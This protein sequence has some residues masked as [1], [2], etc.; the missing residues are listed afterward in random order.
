MYLASLF[1]TEQRPQIEN[2]KILKT[3][4]L[5]TMNDNYQLLGARLGTWLKK[6]KLH[7]WRDSP[8]ATTFKPRGSWIT[9][10][11]LL[12]VFLFSHSISSQVTTY[13]F[14][15]SS[16]TYSEISGGTALV[17]CTDCGTAYDS[18]SY[19]VTLPTP[20]TF[21]FVSV[22][23]VVMRVDGS[24]VVGS[25]ST[26]SATGPI[27]ASTTATGVIAAL[28]MDLRNCTIAGVQYELRWQ[29][30]GSEYVFQWKNA[31]RWAQNT[32]ER[33]NFQIRIVKSTGAISIVYGDFISV[34]NSTTYQP[35][36]GLRG[37]TN[38]DFNSRV[39]TTT[40]PDATPTWD[41]T[42]V[43]TSN[44]Q[45]LRFTS[46][47]PASFPSL[48]FTYTWTPL[49]LEACVT[50]TALASNLTFSGVSTTGLNGSFTAAAPAPSKYLVV[51]ST[52][53]TPPTPVDGTVYTVGATTLGAG[54][55]VRSI[56][57]ATTFSD[58]GLTAGTQYYYHVFSYNDL[59]TGAPFYSTGA[60]TSGQATVCAAGTSISTNTVTTTSATV[61]WTGSGTYI[62]E[63]GPSV[64]F[65]PGTGATA[66]TNGTIASSS[67]T[68]PYSLTGLSSGTNYRVYVRQ[69]CPLGGYSANT[70]FA[71]FTTLCLPELAP[72]A[73]QTFTT[74]TG[75]APNPVCWTEA[76]G[77]VEAPSVLTAANSKW[78][79]S[80][81]FGNVGTNVGAK[82]NLYNT[83]PGDWLISNQID[84]G[85]TP[86]LYR[87]KYRIAVTSW[88]GTTAQASLGTHIVRV[89]V[90]TDGGTTWSS[91]NTIKTYTGEGSYSNTG[92][93]EIVDLTGYSGVVK[94]AFVSTTSSTSP[95]IDFHLDDFEVELT[96]PCLE[97]SAPTVSSFTANTAVVGW[98][99]PSTLPSNGY[100]WAVT[101]SVTPPA[102]GT[103]TTELTVNANGL[104]PNTTHYL[105]VRSNCGANGY[106]A[107][108]TSASFTTPCEAITTLPYFMGFD[109]SAPCWTISGGT[110]VWALANGSSVDISAPYEGTGFAFKPYQS[111]T[112]YLYS[113]PFNMASAGSSQVYL[114]FW[115]YR[116]VSAHINDVITFK[117]N[118][119][120]SN[121]GATTVATY[122]LRADQ[123]PVVA[124]SG[125]YNYSIAIPTSWNSAG[126]FH[127]VIEGATSAGLSSYDIGL[128]SFSLDYAP[129]TVSSFAPTY[130]CGTAGGDTITITGSNFTGATSV[131]FNGIEATSFT[132][133][134]DTTISA[135]V[136]AGNTEGVITVYK[137]PSSNGY[138]TSATAFE[139]K[140]FPT[141]ASITYQNTVVANVAVCRPTTVDLDIATGGGSWSSL[142]EA[143]A[144]VDGNG[145]VTSHQS[146]TVTINYVVVSEF[147]CVT[148]RSATVTFNEPI[149]LL[150]YTQSQTVVT[151][152]T[153]T[154]SVTTN[155]DPSYTY[156]WYSFDGIFEEALVDGPGFAGE[157]YQG[158]TSSTLQ[159]LNTP[160]DLNGFEFFCVI[161]AAAPC[162][163]VT[164]PNAILNV[165]DTG[166]ATDPQNVS[167]C[168]TGSGAAQFSVV[169]T[170]TVNSYQ[171]QLD[172]T[173]EGFW[174]DITDGSML[175]L[176]FS[177]STTNTLNVN[178]IT[179]ATSGLRFRVIVNG[180]ANSPESNP[181]VLTVNE[182]VEITT[183][184]QSA[185]VCKIAGSTQFSV[186]ASG[187][188]T[189]V[190]WKYST[191]GTTYA[192]VTN[193]LP[194][195]ITYSGQTT[196]TLTVNRTAATAVGTYYY[197]AFVSGASPC[198]EQASNAATL[199]VTAPTVAV[200][201]S[202]TTYCNPGT[203]VTLTASGAVS[204][205]WSPMTGLTF[206]GGQTAVASASPT[207]TTTYTVTGTDSNGCSST[208][209]VTVTVNPGVI[210]SLN[211]PLS[212]VCSGAAVPFTLTNSSLIGNPK[213]SGY[214][215][216]S[217][218][219]TY[220][221]VAGTNSTAIGDD[222]NQNTISLGFTFK[223]DGVD[224]TTFSIN[225]NG[226]IRLGTTIAASPWI[227]LLSNTAAQRPLIAPFW[228][229]NHRNAGAIT[230][231]VTGSSPNRILEV[232]WDGI[233]IGG[234][235]STS[236]ANVASYKLRLYE[237]TNVIDF[238]YGP[239]M[240]T[241]GALTA[242][243]G[244]NGNDSFLSVNPT[245][246]P[247]VSSTT[248]SNSINSTVNLVG[249]RFRFTPNV[250]QYTYEWSSVP[251]GFTSSVANPTA[252]PTETT[253]YSV[254]VTGPNGCSSTVS[255]TIT[256][257]SGVAIG[258]QPSAVGPLCQ[259]ANTSF[260][261]V[262]SGPSLQ[263]QWRK[264][265]V[266]VVGN[267][268]ATTATLVLNGVL[269]SQ[270]GV[271][272]V[273]ITPACGE[274]VLSTPQSLIVYP[275]P[276][277]EPIAN[278]NYCSGELA[279]VTTLSGTPAGVT[280]D[281][282]GG[283]AVGLADQ[284]GV[285]SIPSFA[286]IVGSATVTVTPKA[287]G[288]TGIARTYTITVG[289]KPAAIDLNTYS[290]A[291]CSNDN[292]VLLSA[293]GGFD[294][295]A[296]ILKQ[297]FNSGLQGWTVTSGPS[298]PSQSN[299]A[300]VQSPFNLSG[301]IISFTN[302]STQNGGGFLFSNADAGGSGSITNT[303]I[304]SP[305]FS[306][307][308][309]TSSVLTFEH[310]YRYWSSDS[311]VRLEISTNDGSTWSPLENYIGSDKGVTTN[312]SQ[313]T[314]QVSVNLNAYLNQ[315]SLRIRFNYLTTWGYYWI[316]DNVKVTGPGQ[317]A[318]TW[319]PIEGLYTD[320]AATLPYQGEATAS[321]YARPAATQSFVATVNSN[322]G[323]ST[324]S[325]PVQIN[326]TQATQWYADLDGDG[327]G[328]INNPTNFLSCNLSEPGFVTIAG[329]CN[330]NNALIN[331]G[332]A[333]ICFDG[334]D[335]NCDG[336]L[337]ANCTP[338]VVNI[339][340]NVCGSVNNGLN[341]TIQSSQVN[342]GGGYVIGYRFEVTNTETGEVRTIDRNVH[343]FKLTM[344]GD[345]F[346]NYGTTYSIRVAAI[347]NGEV[348][349]YNGATCSI[350]TTSV[351]TTSIVASQCGSTLVTMTS[352][353]NAVA[354]NP[355][356]SKYRFRVARADAPTTFYYVER[357]VP[358]FNLTLVPG[359]PLTFATEY[360][361]A[362]QIRVKLAGFESWSQWSTASCSVFTPVAPTTSVTEADC[363]FIATSNT[364]V[365]HAIPV[366]GATMY[367][368]LLLGFDFD[369]ND[370]MIIVYE[371]FVDTPNPYFT[372][373]MFS[374][375]LPDYNY[376]VSVAVELFGSF[377]PYGKDCSVTTPSITGCVNTTLW[378]SAT[379]TPTCTG[380]AQNITTS[381][382]AGEY[383]NLNLT[384]GVT[385]TLS[386]STITDF[387][388]VT[389]SSN[390]FLV[391]GVT[392]VTFTPY[393]SGVYKM[394]V[395]TNASC[396]SQSSS[397][398]TRVS[399]SN[400]TLRQTPIE[401]DTTASQVTVDF[402][403]IGYP[404]PY[405]EYFT[406]DV[407]SSSTETV[408][409]AIY[410]MTGRLLE[411]KDLKHT[412]L[413][414]YR[415][416][417]AYPSGVYNV[418]VIQGDEM[419]T[420]RMVKK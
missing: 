43:A 200:V 405:V 333:E 238:V 372:L 125:W 322:N 151:G 9:P 325:A 225:T 135:V 373:S 185:L 306:T 128:D 387:I 252:N 41:D 377:T 80:T 207:A 161:T 89:I 175:G 155:A 50:P 119:T 159:I 92:Q 348:Q 137:Q 278:Q 32:V 244:L 403:V 379:F 79:S 64:G 350:T 311:T 320:L 31:S 396:G 236:G 312:N 323:C 401:E 266:A 337:F 177:N 179:L 149:S 364:D 273:M 412:E 117:L 270:S 45:N 75:S 293:T 15:Q 309:A 329:D 61:T 145:V 5:R 262:A 157:T 221:P 416:G 381:L 134:N 47:A 164:S 205:T 94:I 173:V 192:N 227:N 133:V 391:T 224:Y 176:T 298:S 152:N 113:P 37:A 39:L 100:E 331:P 106:S 199:Q 410:D 53:A 10:V 23:S 363:E 334:I 103:P 229:D 217:S 310:L 230:Y 65:T 114:N 287:N 108:V 118:A 257:S 81:G 318:I 2:N 268:T 209:T 76:T 48:G 232:G 102:S 251:A 308:G 338:I 239:V 51:R 346:Y 219:E 11:L 415:L 59:C 407:R 97:P 110:N 66:G 86:G 366:P 215:F 189:G 122:A 383:S 279:N 231:A 146:G 291:I 243:V 138:G 357:T 248:A 218:T 115:L 292:G 362:V 36:V 71:S 96:P 402:K 295:D 60:L 216:E 33:L 361:V 390:A 63:Y 87:L 255:K 204:Y 83:F 91:A 55:N 247:S 324:S 275:T 123:A 198:P 143:I 256:V 148:T 62:V 12:F 111:S 313:V 271:Y 289:Q 301:T 245:A 276:T 299:W 95:D 3:N 30:V 150:D 386:S 385:Y 54:T 398:T 226:F 93:T 82:I 84:L 274:S 130:V 237:T 56:T 290:E 336:S 303:V 317:G 281:V 142:N 26:S 399:C 136:P 58:S 395:N 263:Y 404:N 52:S 104:T 187:A 339:T 105:H 354:V 101:T 139:V 388:T 140:P 210:V 124:S 411:S 242:S 353:I 352:S 282:T 184:P 165:G 344:F 409:Y 42:A 234:G 69:V 191:D 367:R 419:Q 181:A 283:A 277:L 269:P 397:R 365:I 24:L 29:D 394:H 371:Q 77:A 246:T 240:N 384:A 196:T 297:D 369:A 7:V 73:V 249:K 393:V 235:G 20:F 417:S 121:T 22:S 46:G 272:D 264:D 112:Q 341:N 17:S 375:L 167:L 85:A 213:V 40:V 349:P 260:S 285:T 342:L 13:T 319:S 414:S 400:G 335:N 109:G 280:F 302:F 166:I 305:S 214:S 202:S 98:S 286:V 307:V 8:D 332:V 382:F 70:T 116:N 90:S 147:G 162:E 19:V 126:T 28:G 67:A 418:I 206:E 72:T 314:A 170:G 258:T 190:Q 330:D 228:D 188:T 68:S 153:A 154:Y 193:N 241:A 129:V 186:A 259:G 316:L 174:Q 16:G 288:C 420:I 368:F 14:S 49:V 347:V 156:Q 356:P 340:S 160:D 57:N 27:S 131:Q 141:V 413:E 233:N 389:S 201:A 168:S 169:S 321:V 406:L 250:P 180:P 88:N 345:D 267:A 343:H 380:V 74:F 18:N 158:A 171:W 203:P 408:R 195:G 6:Q 197:K 120:A 183:H 360:L 172:E 4:L 392:P 326:V 374:G 35:Q 261:V 182:G 351:G 99:A 212:E 78:T 21:N 25:N 127:V 284:F 359:L 315:P 358:N 370:E 38:A 378:P 376:S 328:D 144:T 220:T 178:G 265:G 208:T 223:F 211:S 194:A 327:Y 300:I 107:W 132:V 222:G 253:T 163:A 304:T 44:S 1:Y 34:A 254:V 355:S 294:T 296:A